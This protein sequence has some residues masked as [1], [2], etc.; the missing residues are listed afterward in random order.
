MG[1]IVKE[2]HGMEC[3]SFLLKIFSFQIRKN[4]KSGE[5]LKYLKFSV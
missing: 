5:K 4:Y 3:Q 1:K 2:N